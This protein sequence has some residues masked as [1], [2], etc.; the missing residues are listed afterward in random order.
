MRDLSLHLLDIIQNSIAAKAGKIITII[1][2]NK[3]D[4]ELG[5]IVEDN[6]HGMDKE[7]LDKVTD[8]FVT[9]RKTRKIGIGLPLLK[10]SSEMAGGKLDIDSARGKGT[11][12]KSTFKIG[13]IDRLP[14]GDISDTFVSLIAA[15]PDIEFE[16]KLDNGEKSFLFNSFEIKKKLDG[17]PITEYEVLS[18]LKEFIDEGVKTIFGGVLNEVDS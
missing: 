14:L 17:V 10:S 4:D 1:Y 9:T 6:G 12:L 18:W 2:A 13:H 8:P 15:R 16:L 11:I 7:F 3:L 5:I